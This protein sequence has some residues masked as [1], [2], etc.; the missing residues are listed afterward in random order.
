MSSNM[1]LRSIIETNKLTRSNFLDG[2]RNFRIVLKVEKI[3][4]VL[5]GP[6]FASLAIDASK[7]VQRGILEASR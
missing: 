3:A 5:D 7:G 1:N 6:L 2:L 4:Y